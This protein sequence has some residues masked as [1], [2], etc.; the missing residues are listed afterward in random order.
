LENQIG[1]EATK[2]LIDIWLRET[3]QRVETIRQAVKEG[4]NQIAKK[5]AHALRGGC[6]I[7]GLAG[8]VECCKII[9]AEARLSKKVS[10]ALVDKLISEVA[11]GSKSLQEV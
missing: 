1:T 6:S 5:A 8:I 7:F 11:E 2:E 10:K 4:R 3:P 9:E